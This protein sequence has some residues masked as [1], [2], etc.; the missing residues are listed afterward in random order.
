MAGFKIWTDLDADKT[1][2]LCR[3]VAEKLEFTVRPIDDLAFA[4]QKGNLAVSILVGAIIAYCDFE[5]FI[6]DLGDE[7]EIRIER[8]TPWWTGLIGVRRVKS[9]A[10][11]LADAIAD[12]IEDE[13]G[14]VLKEK[15]F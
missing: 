5:V 12:R 2:R 15:E 11:D 4:A 13:D 14:R 9:R 6:E 7:T 1:Y 3:R 8:N 10:K